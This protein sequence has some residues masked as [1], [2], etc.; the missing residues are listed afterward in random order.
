MYRTGLGDC[1]LLAFPRAGGPLYL[2]IDC[3]VYAGTPE[4]GKQTRIRQIVEDIR[5]ATGGRLD[6]L[7]ITHEHWDHVSAF[8]PS[9]AQDIFAQE[10]EL[11][12]LWMA[13]TENRRIPLARDLQDGRRA[14]RA[15]LRQAL[16]RMQGYAANGATTKLV[17]KVLDFFGGDGVLGAKKSVKTDEA[18]DWLRE[19]NGKGKA[20]FLRPGEDPLTLEGVSGARVYML[21]PHGGPPTSSSART[22]RATR[23]IPRPWPRRSSPRSSPPA[24]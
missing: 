17:G 14:A 21:G 24:A 6:V 16:S 7:V 8:H 4:P 10:I 18:M 9:Q 3:G 11:G 12:A 15:A 22:P 23:S 5:D 2:M 1:F 20:R 13:W 19:S